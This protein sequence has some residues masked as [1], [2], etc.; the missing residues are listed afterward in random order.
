MLMKSRD[1]YNTRGSDA[2]RQTDRLLLYF[3][4][5]CGVTQCDVIEAVLDSILT[6]LASDEVGNSYAIAR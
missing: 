4:V 3:I 1:S 6:G 2:L 5:L